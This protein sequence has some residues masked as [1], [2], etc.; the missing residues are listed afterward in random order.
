MWVFT[1]F[2]PHFVVG[3]MKYRISIDITRFF[4]YKI[5]FFLYL[6]IFYSYTFSF[7]EKRWISLRGSWGLFLS[8]P[9][10]VV[11]PLKKLIFIVSCLSH[12]EYLKK[13][14]MD[15]F[16]RENVLLFRFG[17]TIWDKEEKWWE[18]MFIFSM[19]NLKCILRW[20]SLQLHLPLQLPLYL[21]LPLHLLPSNQFIR[22]E[23]FLKISLLFLGFFPRL[24]IFLN[25]RVNRTDFPLSNH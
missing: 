1:Y 9:P 13:E 25:T 20:I 11:Q 21:P 24:M 15:I 8:P 17:W 4:R 3:K 7:D 22:M 2:F 5:S 19:K 16:Y 12:W 18:K 14:T 23:F 10:L 6:F